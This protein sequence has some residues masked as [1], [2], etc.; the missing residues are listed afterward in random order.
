MNR[1]KQL[2]TEHGLSMREVA[3]RINVPYTTYVNY[4]KGIRDP[5]TEVL[6]KLAKFFE[7]TVDYL[8]GISDNVSGNNFKLPE[9]EETESGLIFSFGGNNEKIEIS[10]EDANKFG[11]IFDKKIPNLND[12]YEAIRIKGEIIKLLQTANLN[13]QQLKDIKVIINALS[14]VNEE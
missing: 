10:P 9:I 14:N 11:K 4:E 6:A 8:L 3:N 1:L 12:E 2:R 5:S 7:T 13:I